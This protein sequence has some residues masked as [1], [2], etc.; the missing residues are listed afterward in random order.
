MI[1]RVV[2]AVVLTA[3]LLAV[4]TPAMA[5]AG[6]SRAD[7]TMDRR[8]ETLSTDLGTMVE[9]DDPTAGRGARHVVELRVPG[10]SL[11]SAA[12]TRL[13]FASR[14][15]VGVASWR[16]G[17]GAETGSKRLAGVPIRGADS[18]ALTLREPGT[19]RLVF[20]LRSRAGEPVLTVRRLGGES[21]A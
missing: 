7:S 17:D 18:G 3:A 13:R 9:T 5:D 15:G 16:V 19:H 10:R 20:E 2:L 21:D 11:T 14:E 6:A 8:L 4:A 1:F 12:V